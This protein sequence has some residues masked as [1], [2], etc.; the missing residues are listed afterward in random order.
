MGGQVEI[1][2]PFLDVGDPWT[3]AAF[4]DGL[5]NQGYGPG[6]TS[7]PALPVNALNAKPHQIGTD[8]LFP[9]GGGGSGTPPVFVGS[10]T[11]AVFNGGGVVSG[12][13]AITTLHANEFA[14]FCICSVTDT[15][16]GTILASLTATGLTPARRAYKQINVPATANYSFASE[17]WGI[18]I[19]TAGTY[20]LNFTFSSYNYGYALV[21]LHA[22][23]VDLTSPWDSTPTKIITPAIVAGG[24]PI[25]VPIG[26]LV[27]AQSP[28]LAIVFA[29]AKQGLSDQTI[30]MGPGA[31]QGGYAANNPPAGFTIADRDQNTPPFLINAGSNVSLCYAGAPAATTLP[32]NWNYPIDSD[33]CVFFLDSL[34]GA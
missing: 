8:T 33:A 24:P 6:P 19:P 29:S 16:A 27:T 1:L 23:G 32:I 20:T 31:I 9:A 7:N 3:R 21:G 15:R 25:S 17:I 22:T 5:T 30:T 11:G 26:S 4:D 10:F 12:S 28:N 14:V 34:T 13:K 2:M 18:P